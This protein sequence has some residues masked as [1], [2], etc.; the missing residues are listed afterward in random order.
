MCLKSY[1][2]LSFSFSVANLY[3]DIDHDVLNP[4]R[5][6]IKSGSEINRFFS[7]FKKI[8]FDVI[9]I[10]YEKVSVFVKFLWNR[11]LL[12][13]VLSWNRHSGIKVGNELF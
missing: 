11:T 9:H 3:K 13:S 2:C 4:L 7:F 8:L 1:F 12:N 5:I 6:Q 10:L